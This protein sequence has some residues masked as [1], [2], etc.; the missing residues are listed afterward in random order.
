MYAALS[1]GTFPSYIP[2]SYEDA[3]SKGWKEA[4][5]EELTTLE[6]NHTWDIV[7]NPGNVEVI[8]SKWVFCEKLINGDLKK[9]A[10]LVA[11]GCN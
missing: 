4:V 7:K 8:D 9:K 1:T 6:E 11:R 2:E 10:R 5:D 3:V